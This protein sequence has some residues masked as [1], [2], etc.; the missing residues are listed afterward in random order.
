MLGIPTEE[1]AIDWTQVVFNMLTLKGIYGRE[2]YETWYKMTV[3]LQ[4]GLD[5]CPGH[6]A[7]LSLLR[8]RG[9]LRRRRARASPARSCS[10]GRRAERGHRRFATTCAAQ[11]ADIRAA[12]LYKPE[13]SHRARR[14]RPRSRV[15]GPRPGAEPLRQQLPGPGRPPGDRRGRPRGARAVGLR[16]G[17]GAVHLRHAGGPPRARGAAG[18]VP[19][20]GGHDPLRLVLRRQRRPVRD[21]ARPRGRRHLRRAEPRLDH[22]RHPPLQGPAAA[23]REQRHGR[24]GGAAARGRR[25]PPP[26]DRHRRRVLDGRLLRPPAGD[27]R[28]GRAPRRAW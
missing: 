28:P 16:H 15:V 5:I 2:M 3:M 27:L 12:G 4:S 26:P 9:G 11:L 25:R 7:P 8:V 6:H 20:H 13:R 21:A 17:V 14:S 23:L 19:R 18:R 10:T 22:R 24:P 1:I